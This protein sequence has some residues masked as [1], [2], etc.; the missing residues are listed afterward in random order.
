M[1][2][3]GSFD[4][5]A[6]ARNRDLEEQ[7][8]E[9]TAMINRW[10]EGIVQFTGETRAHLQFQKP[11]RCIIRFDVDETAQIN[12]AAAILSRLPIDIETL[13]M[14]AAIAQAAAEAGCA[15]EDLCSYLLA[16]G[17]GSLTR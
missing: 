12:R 10:T 15:P 5:E 8:E 14:K 13:P 11:G 6:N 9:N 4:K 17:I 1:E 7:L 16:L 2:T 3:V